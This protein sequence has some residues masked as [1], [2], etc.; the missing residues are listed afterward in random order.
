MM[1]GSIAFY[2]EWFF[3]LDIVEEKNE[4]LSSIETWTRRQFKRI[5]PRKYYIFRTVPKLYVIS[6][7][8]CFEFPAYGSYEYRIKLNEL[9]HCLKED[10]IVDKISFDGMVTYQIRGVK[11]D[12]D[13]GR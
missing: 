7:T 13:K 10:F 3:D 8:I 12:R 5:M 1:R 6:N 9:Y 2:I 4:V 11:H